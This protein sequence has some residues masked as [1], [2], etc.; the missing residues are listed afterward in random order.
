MPHT[1]VR[2]IRLTVLFNEDVFVCVCVCVL[3]NTVGIEKERKMPIN[4]IG[5]GVKVVMPKE[6]IKILNKLKEKKRLL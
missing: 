5:G 3:A 2:K 4:Q 6:K 1:F